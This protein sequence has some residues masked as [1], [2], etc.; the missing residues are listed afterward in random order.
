MNKKILIPIIVLV[1]IIFGAIRINNSPND[2]NKSKTEELSDYKEQNQGN[3]EEDNESSKDNTLNNG[4]D[5][6]GI[7]TSDNNIISNSTS[8]SDNQ[9]SNSD[10]QNSNETSK[11]NQEKN[12][13]N[14]GTIATL[15]L[16]YTISGSGADIKVQKINSYSGKFVEDGSDKKVSNIISLVVKNNSRKDIQYTS[17]EVSINGNER[18]KFNITN[19]PSGQS[20]TVIESTGKIKYKSGDRYNIVNCTYSDIDKLPMNDNKIKVSTNDSSIKIKNISNK[21]LGTVYVYYKNTKGN[22]YLGGITYR[23][24]FENVDKG[25]ELTG[26]T[27]HFSKNSEIVMVDTEN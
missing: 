5:N 17:I 25:K 7:N 18:A 24:K 9:N 6:E 4:Q 8:G 12:E 3:N 13:A 19:L 23:A 2:S 26:S 1:F 10:N 16:P 15:K 14:K 11:D 22:S 21:N 27:K 20:A